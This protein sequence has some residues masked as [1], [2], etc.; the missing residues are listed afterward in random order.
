L[1]STSS[2]APSEITSQPCL[3]ALAA[4]VY[5]TPR[6]DVDE[7]ARLLPQLHAKLG[8]IFMERAATNHDGLVPDK[9]TDSLS[10]AQPDD[11]TVHA[12]LMQLA[13]LRYKPHAM[14]A[15]QYHPPSVLDGGGGREEVVYPSLPPSSGEL[16]V[17]V[18][19]GVPLPVHAG[20]VAP[21]APPPE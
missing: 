13:P 19:F 11:A 2:V 21:S 12:Y 5:A 10:A 14:P 18:A 20:G 4:L 9:V 16:P 15:P 17:P 3:R 6:I 1:I 8:Q 7:L